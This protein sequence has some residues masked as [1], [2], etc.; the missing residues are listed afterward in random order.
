MLTKK[1]E[2]ANANERATG[3]KLAGRCKIA[4][5]NDL[6]Q[7]QSRE[8]QNANFWVPGGRRKN[9]QKTLLNDLT[10]VW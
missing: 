3:G 6:N 7:A 5:N 4:A 10:A 1:N 8:C 2:F 9:L